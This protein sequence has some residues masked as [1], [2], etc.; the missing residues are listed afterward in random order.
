MEFRIMGVPE[1]C[2]DGS[3]RGLRGPRQCAVLTTLALRANE[4]VSMG[5]LTDAVWDRLPASPASNIRTYVL[6]IRRLLHDAA[7]RLHTGQGGYRLEVGPG[8]L[9]A[10]EFGML[11]ERGAAALRDG[12]VDAAVDS[13]GRALRLWRGQPLEGV[14]VG[15]QLRADVVRLED[16]MVT[17][18]EQLIQARIQACD[19]NTAAGE[20]RQLLARYPFRERLWGQLM[21]ALFRSGRQAEALAAYHEVRGVLVAE[22]GVEPGAELRRVYQCM[23]VAA[24]QPV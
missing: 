16:R 18:H 20:A 21:T 17:V 2:Q 23:V 10:A 15:P 24:D 12:R 1:I 13:F 8:E 22:L 5:A 4:V 11:A 14:A 3:V 9:D 19:H 7:D 6:E